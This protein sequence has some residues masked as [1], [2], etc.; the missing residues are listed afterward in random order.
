[1]ESAP[2][3]PHCSRA[4]CP[5]FPKTHPLLLDSWA[6]IPEGQAGSTGPELSEA[7][8]GQVL[9]VQT[10]VISELLLHLPHDWQNPGLAVICAISWNTAKSRVRG[11]RQASFKEKQA[12]GLG[13]FH[14]LPSNNRERNENQV[15]FLTVHLL[16]AKHWVRS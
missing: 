8:D 5:S 16:W 12:L 14:L 3:P 7:E 10:A 15:H 6:V 13:A 1:M 2:Q 11:M 9:M 4:N